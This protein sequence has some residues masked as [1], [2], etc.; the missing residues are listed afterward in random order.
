MQIIWMGRQFCKR[1]IRS[2]NKHLFN[3]ALIS[4]HTQPP[5]PLL[6]LSLSLT[7]SLTLIVSIL[8]PII[9]T[10]RSPGTYYLSRTKPQKTHN[11][12]TLLEDMILWWGK[13]MKVSRL[14]SSLMPSCF[15]LLL[16]KRWNGAGLWKPFPTR[17][18]LVKSGRIT[19]AGCPGLALVLA[20]RKKNRRCRSF[21]SFNRVSRQESPKGN[22]SLAREVLKCA[23]G[24]SKCSENQLC[25]QKTILNRSQWAHTWKSNDLRNP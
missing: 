11:Q 10:S 18:R 24:C 9:F 17:K 2:M 8:S 3:T 6:F 14:F 25:Q 1:L 13:K 21:S 5:S 4:K 15:P 19:E 7:H 16:S 22:Q 20:L 12:V 23:P